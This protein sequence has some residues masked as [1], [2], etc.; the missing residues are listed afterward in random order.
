V[1]VALVAAALLTTTQLAV[2]DGPPAPPTGLI[3]DMNPHWRAPSPHMFNLLWVVAADAGGY[4][5]EV[6]RGLPDR[7]GT[8]AFVP[9]ETIAPGLA[10]P[11]DFANVIDDQTSPGVRVCYRVRAV[12]PGRPSSDWSASACGDLA[13][14]PL[15]LQMAVAATVLPN[16]VSLSWQSQPGADIG[17]WPQMTAIR[18]DNLT[19]WMGIAIVPASPKP[20]SAFAPVANVPARWCFR[21]FVI[22]SST[23]SV[24]PSEETC[25]DYPGASTEAPAPTAVITPKP[26]PT[27]SGSAPPRGPW[28][29]TPAASVVVMLAG[30]GLLLAAHRGRAAAAR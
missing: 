18:P 26:P 21:V 11:G 19:D 22:S 29:F 6:E 16:G 27:G 1:L 2:A 28:F 23:V 7:A 4:G 17:Y 15:P 3:L 30:I 20:L 25:L 24:A 14:A 12:A 9:W 5:W 10:S 8:V 13:Q